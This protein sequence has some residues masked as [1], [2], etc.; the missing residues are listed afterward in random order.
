[1]SNGS[2]WRVAVGVYLGGM[3][4]VFSTT[5][6]VVAVGHL[7]LEQQRDM[8]YLGGQRLLMVGEGSRRPD[9]SSGRK[10][11]ARLPEGHRCINGQ[12]FRKVDNGWVQL[13]ATCE[14]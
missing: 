6:L 2:V 4:V 8:A 11:N 14:P 10:P 12:T 3:G 13:S 5:L 9:Y 7:A 1:M